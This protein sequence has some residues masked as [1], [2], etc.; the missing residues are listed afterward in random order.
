[1]EIERKFLVNSLEG[2]DLSKYKNKR[3]IQD[4]LYSDKFTAIRK[5]HIIVN[6]EHKYIYT[7][8]TGKAKFSVNEIEKEISEEEYNLLK[9]NEQ[10]N[11]IDKIRYLIPYENGLTIELDVFK[12]AYEGIV[13]GEIEFESEEQA[14]NVEL[15]KWFG[16]ELTSKVTNSMMARMNI[17]EARKIIEECNI[18]N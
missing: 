11:T 2:I 4:Y 13:F 18:N 17:Q 12:G 5:R 10:N 14:Q 1:M 6:D 16:N 15:P 7:I 3:I 9:I 8:K